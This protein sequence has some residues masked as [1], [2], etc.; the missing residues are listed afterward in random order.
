M[1]TIQEYIKNYHDEIEENRQI[2]IKE[3]GNDI[4]FDPFTNIESINGIVGYY[5]E[6]Y[7]ENALS[8]WLDNLKNSTKKFLTDGAVTMILKTF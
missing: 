2:Y 4:E 1:K 8:V 3:V 6:Q 7:K 5:L